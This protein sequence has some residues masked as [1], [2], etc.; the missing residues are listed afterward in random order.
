MLNS[1]FRSCI[2]AC[3]TCA[4]AGGHCAASC[5]QQTNASEMARCIRLSIDCAET[6]LT[7]ASLMARSSEM[8]GVLCQACAYVCEACA[9]E[10]AKHGTE[11]CDRCAEACRACAEE[12]QRLAA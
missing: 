5:L 4:E 2:E 6:C 12:C 9:E 11:H 10:C 3:Y 1:Q 7:T 8:S